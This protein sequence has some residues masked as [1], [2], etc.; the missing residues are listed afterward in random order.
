MY[1]DSIFYIAEIIIFLFRQLTYSYEYI[2]TVGNTAKL[3]TALSNIQTAQKYPPLHVGSQ[4]T[5]ES[6]HKP[7]MAARH[8]H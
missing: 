8:G 4:H 3:G 5:T 1:G 7:T 2:G 6:A